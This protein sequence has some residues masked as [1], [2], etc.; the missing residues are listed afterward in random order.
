MGLDD[1]LPVFLQKPSINSP[2]NFKLLTVECGFQLLPQKLS[3][4]LFHGTPSK[5]TSL[6]ADSSL[7]ASTELLGA[8]P[9][10]L[11]FLRMAL[12]YSTELQ[13]LPTITKSLGAAFI[14][15]V[16][17]PENPQNPP[18]FSRGM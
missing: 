7:G 9:P 8:P 6:M 14:M 4:V 13:P 11:E 18:C 12:S 10:A 17:E 3:G 5:A 1:V 15:E 16:G 2:D